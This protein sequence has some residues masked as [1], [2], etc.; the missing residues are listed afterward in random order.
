MDDMARIIQQANA[1]TISDEPRT[2]TSTYHGDSK[3]AALGRAYSIRDAI[4]DAGLDCTA[5]LTG[6]AWR[7]ETT[8]FYEFELHIEQD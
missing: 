6:R 8:T 1:G 2:I 3:E 4:R 5:S 7:T